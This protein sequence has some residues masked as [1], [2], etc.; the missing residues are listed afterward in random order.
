MTHRRDRYSMQTAWMRVVFVFAVLSAAVVCLQAD[1]TKPVLDVGSRRQLLF[2]ELFLEQAVGVRL[3]VNRPFQDPDPVLVPDQPW[4]QSVSAY[5]TVLQDEGRFRM[6]YDVSTPATDR[7]PSRRVVCYAESDDGVRWRK[8]IVGQI[9]WNGSRQNN[10]VAPSSAAGGM[11]GAAVFRDDQGPPAE[12]YKLWTKYYPSEE[13][14]AQGI[15]PGLYAFVSPDGLRWTMLGPE[16][17]Y[18]L[19]RGNAADS[20]NL[21]FWDADAGKYI[22]FVRM[23]RHGPP[24]RDRTC[25]VGLMTSDDFENWTTAR[26]VFRADEQMAVP[27]RQ[28]ERLPPVDLYTPGGMKV[29]GIPNAYILL[30]TYYY[31][32]RQDAFPSTIDAGLATS[33]DRVTWWRPPPEDRQPFLR[34][35]PDRSASSGMLFSFPW[36]VSVGRETWIYYG[37]IGHDHRSEEPSYGSGIFRSRLRREGFVSVDAGYRGGEF[38][39][40][41]LTFSGDRLELNLDG[42]AGGWLQV[43][44]QSADGTPIS[45]RQIDS[46]DTVRGN[47]LARTVSWSG[48]S[49]VSVLAGTPVRL[50]FVM[51]SMKLYSFRFAETER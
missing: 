7:E 22:A 5:T 38:T 20:H 43:E 27:G 24:P 19:S 39:T 49:D 47:A 37:G 45:G 12:R 41:V 50:R 13:E 48:E 35:G 11:G 3:R 9:E 25:W 30:P 42:S 17:G 8:P 28:P 29:P 51:R 36:P 14:T 21:C 1:E 23:K 44:I 15:R 2:D 32:W 26:E 18:P 46:C 6:W 10:I 40:P 31:H 4:E 34:L 16:R 33:R